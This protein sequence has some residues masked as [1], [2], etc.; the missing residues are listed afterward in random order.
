M[1]TG[2]VKT[3]FDF[4][5]NIK[6]RIRSTLENHPETRDSDSIL[7]VT[8]W[9]QEIKSKYKSF[10]VNVGTFLNHV[11]ENKFSH[12][13]TVRRYRQMIQREFPHLRGKRFNKRQVE[14]EVV[15]EKVV[16]GKL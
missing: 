10:N 9:K 12:T 11:M 3:L 2:N 1:E 8:I 7:I 16:N 14:A 4:N 6:E 15:K 5:P 13:E